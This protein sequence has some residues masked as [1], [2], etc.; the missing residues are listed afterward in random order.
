MFVIVY[1]IICVCVRSTCILDFMDLADPSWS[2]AFGLNC[3]VILLLF[4]YICMCVCLVLTFVQVPT[5]S[6]SLAL[7]S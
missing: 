6:S 7:G 3:S 1:V 4:I 5:Q 2:L